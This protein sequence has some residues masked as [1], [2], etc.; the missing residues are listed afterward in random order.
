MFKKVVFLAFCRDIYRALIAALLC[1]FVLFSHAWAA[2]IHYNIF[3]GDD[4]VSC[5]VQSCPGLSSTCYSGYCSGTYTP[6]D[7]LIVG[8]PTNSTQSHPFLRWE[9]V[10]GTGCLLVPDSQHDGQYRLFNC[11]GI[12]ELDAVWQYDITYNL[13]KPVGVPSL[14]AITNKPSQ[15]PQHVE[16]AQQGL[17]LAGAPS[18]AGYTFRGWHCYDPDQETYHNSNLN[19]SYYV[20]VRND[21]PGNTPLNAYG[22]YDGGSQVDYGYDDCVCE[23]IWGMNNGHEVP[24]YDCVSNNQSTSLIFYRNADANYYRNYI[25]GNFSNQITNSNPLAVPNSTCFAGYDH[26]AE[27][28]DSAHSSVDIEGFAVDSY[29]EIYISGN[30]NVNHLIATYLDSHY[31]LK[32]DSSDADG[33]SHGTEF[34]WYCHGNGDEQ[35]ANNGHSNTAYK[36]VVNQNVSPQYHIDFT[37][38]LYSNSSYHIDVPTRNG[39]TFAGYFD[40]SGTTRYI[41]ENGSVTSAGA[42]AL[43]GMNWNVSSCNVWY[44][45]WC[46]GNNQTINP[47]GTCQQTCPEGE[48]L[49]I[50]DDLNLFNPEGTLSGFGFDVE[51]TDFGE[52]QPDYLNETPNTFGVWNVD[53]DEFLLGSAMCSTDDE[54]LSPA[55]SLN[56][57]SQHPEDN[58]YCWCSLTGGVQ[59]GVQYS[60]SPSTWVYLTGDLGSG[61]FECEKYCAEYCAGLGEITYP[62][63]GYSE[64]IRAMLKQE[65]CI[66]QQYK[67]S[68]YCNREDW[69]N[70]ASP[71]YS[72]TAY[73]G[74]TGYSFIAHA[75]E[76]ESCDFGAGYTFGTFQCMWHSDSEVM[77]DDNDANPWSIEDDVDCFVE[78]APEVFDI[79]LNKVNGSG[80]ANRVYTIYNR[81]VY[82]DSNRNVPMTYPGQNGHNSASNI[83]VPT[84]SGFVFD[85]YWSATGN[86]G[87]QY[88]DENGYITQN[89][90]NVGKSLTYNG[91][92]WA[93]WT[94]KTYPISYGSGNHGSVP[95][96][97]ADPVVYQDG[98]TY[99]STWTTKT[100][101][102]TGIVADT[103][104]VFS[105][106]NTSADGSGTSYTANTQQSAWTTDSGLTLYAI[107]GC[108]TGYTMN[109]NNECVQQVNSYNVIYRDQN[110]YDNTTVSVPTGTL[111]TVLGIGDTTITIPMGYVF[112]HW[113][114]YIDSVH[115]YD[116]GDTFTMPNQDVVCRAVLDCDTGYAWNNAHTQCLKTYDVEYHACASQYLDNNDTTGSL[117]NI[118]SMINPQYIWGYGGAGLKDIKTGYRFDT[119]LDANNTSYATG[120]YQYDSNQNPY[121]L[122]LDDNTSPLQ[123]YAQCVAN[124]TNVRYY[125]G[126]N[127]VYSDYATYDQSYTFYNNAT[128]CG[129][130]ATVTGW[131]CSYFSKQGTLSNRP[132]SGPHNVG[133]TVTWNDPMDDYGTQYGY[134]CVAVTQGNSYQITYSGG[135]ATNPNNPNSATHAVTTVAMSPQNVHYGDQDVTLNANTYSQEGYNFDGWSC[136]GTV[137]GQLTSDTDTFDDGQN[138]GIYKFG[139][140]LACTAQWTPEKYTVTYDYG[141]HAANNATGAAYTHTNG[142][143][144]D[145]NYTV[146]AAANAAITPATGYV[147]VGWN[148][149]SGQTTEN[150]SGAT[151]WTQTT[152]L[153]VYAAYACDTA[154]GYI[155][156]NDYPG[157]CVER[158]T[159][160]YRSGAHG[161]G[162][163]YVVVVGDG[164][165]H[166]LLDITD[167]GISAQN[168]Y[169]FGGWQCDNGVTRGPG[170]N[171]VMNGSDVICV[172]QWTPNEIGL[173]WMLNSGH[174][175]V[176]ANENELSN[177]N[178]C[179]Y[180]TLN[181]ITVYDPVRRG[182][183]FI[184]WEVEGVSGQ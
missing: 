6:G 164:D 182:F 28:C 132:Y 3:S 111:H 63:G 141:A 40:Q 17:Y 25:S 74:S 35:C 23:A 93:H 54:S 159:V 84:K 52:G 88:I 45:H 53:Q 81:N 115:D 38:P 2:E 106:W 134:D 4:T 171:F 44:A 89:G 82:K 58:K 146:P 135:T 125:C 80:G 70:N 136:T 123:L 9:I 8:T 61:W 66:P 31:A 41:D 157:V 122:N 144:Y 51:G 178:S 170:Y 14:D 175:Q 22:F 129:P 15:N 95:N 85:G 139:T 12:V 49:N 168:G 120:Y 166:E 39:Y 179:D 69:E 167:V 153:T 173:N 160:T 33:G 105:G 24:V 64:F 169:Y 34:L 121:Y 183:G 114:C 79:T 163:D 150:W 142:A 47:D 147:F 124:Q 62:G 32:L 152:G 145:A 140:N 60:L 42:T 184:G 11:S 116:P 55:S 94:P 101:A 113:T 10:S 172:A 162:Q 154:N 118:I 100:F 156:S 7:T 126:E 102:E 67:V 117:T 13:N 43:A 92:W 119:W 96:N 109:S 83:S 137:C 103:G 181:G 1:F 68:Y 18:A 77:V 104:Y 50:L 151:P 110:Q 46:N 99:G 176:D 91:T 98:L 130:C 127:M 16:S 30:G 133:Q 138:I 174:W 97:G 87:V 155:E 107:Y 161:S 37:T 36:F 65:Y 86:N 177:Q 19:I 72:D 78:A 57:D 27:R 148:T 20:G 165:E 90:L 71:V 180:G 73:D 108:D 143:T 59:N 5:D 128:A 131:N 56:V 112:D 26:L 29:G 21:G 149:S 76:V 158:L 75:S 48:S